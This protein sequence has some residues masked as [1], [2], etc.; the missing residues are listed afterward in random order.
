MH[1]KQLVE[2]L[3]AL[4]RKRSFTLDL[5]CDENEITVTITDNETCE[6]KIIKEP[7]SPDEH[8]DFDTELGNEIY[9][10]AELMMDEGKIELDGI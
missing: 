5:E 2:K 1:L 7:Y 8:L 6:K 9:S 4:P 3:N 10:W